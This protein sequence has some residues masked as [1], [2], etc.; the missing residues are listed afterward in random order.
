MTGE[1]TVP[2]RDEEEWPDN[3]ALLTPQ[4]GMRAFMPDELVAC[5]SCQRANA[6]TR[7]KCLYCGAALPASAS[8]PDLRRPALRA[9]E[10]WEQGYNVILLPRA[11]AAADLTSDA[12]SAAARLLRLEP[13][14]LRR[15]IAARTHLP[16]ARTAVREEAAL[17]ENKL[18][19]LGLAVEI[20]ADETLAVEACPPQRV[21]RCEFADAELIAWSSAEGPA[22][23]IAWTEIVL[24]VAGRISRR[25]IE[26][27]E[28]RGRRAASEVVET[29]EFY[30]DE[31]VL[32]L[33]TSEPACNWRI[34]AASFD[35][36][37][38]G[39]QKSLL[40][41]ENFTRLY[42]ALRTRAVNAMCDDAYN[43]LRHLLQAA[44]PVAEQTSAG[45]L[46]RDRPGRL[47]TEAVTSISNETQFTR[48][49]RL[50]RHFALQQRA[51]SVRRVRARRRE[52]ARSCARS[53]AVERGPALRCAAR[54]RSLARGWAAHGTHHGCGG[55]ARGA[56]ARVVRVG[57]GAS[58]AG[59]PCAAR[60]VA[61]AR[62]GRESSGRRRQRRG[63]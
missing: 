2:P 14:Q 41:A 20:V 5:P 36:T 31:G 27:E 22:Q 11:E 38:L 30:D 63:G 48:Y 6:P 61:A 45:G 43:S 55:R 46:R 15:I 59:A 8:A 44:W 21:R 50:H 47:H 3:D 40:A 37:C 34:K 7:M 17:I 23:R 62:A 58:C 16:L 33:Y 49:G 54:A 18:T 60:G 1:M 35:Y 51:R 9:L 19:P 26:V 25:Q 57:A 29:R 53:I 12:L 28:R 13:E 42:A 4:P 10:T 56:A 24:L 32:D 52:R 39:A